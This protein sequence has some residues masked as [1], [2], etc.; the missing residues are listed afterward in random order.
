MG[1]T[2]EP[3]SSSSVPKSRFGFIPD[4]ASYQLCTIRNLTH[5]RACSPVRQMD[6]VYPS[7]LGG[8]IRKSNILLLGKE[9]EYYIREGTRGEDGRGGYLIVKKGRGGCREELGFLQ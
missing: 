7:L 4:S 2:E 1:F 9:S 5:L 3:V 6:A 8:E